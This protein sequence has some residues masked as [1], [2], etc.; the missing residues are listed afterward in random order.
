MEP[1]RLA[2]LD[3]EKRL[4]HIQPIGYEENYFAVTTPVSLIVAERL[5]NRVRL[6]NCWNRP[7]SN[8]SINNSGLF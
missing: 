5:L 8:E 6:H 1:I 3:C 7:S 2:S 4:K